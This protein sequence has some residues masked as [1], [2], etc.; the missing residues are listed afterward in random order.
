MNYLDKLKHLTQRPADDHALQAGDLI[1]WDRAGTMQ[2]GIVDS[3]YTD[4]TTTRWAFVTL[5]DGTWAAVN[6]KFAKRGER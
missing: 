1:E 3:L 2:T 5:P 6:L 4:E